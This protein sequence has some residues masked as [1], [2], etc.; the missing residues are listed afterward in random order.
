MER[1]EEM[2]RVGEL[3]QTQDN[4]ITSHPIFVVEQKRSYVTD[5]DYSDARL[6]WVDDE[7][8]EV[9]RN[10]P[11]ARRLYVHD[12]WEFVTACFTEKGCNDYLSVNGHN[13]AETRIFVH[14]GFRNREWQNVREHL[15]A[16][17]TSANLK[18]PQQ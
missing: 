8:K 5:P 9:P 10:E 12:V 1:N 2:A 16:L 3:I 4:H 17:A 11:G 6:I 13:L 7:G 14:S 15:I 18:E